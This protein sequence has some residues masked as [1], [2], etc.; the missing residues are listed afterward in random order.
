MRSENLVLR[1]E[2]EQFQSLL[3]RLAF[4]NIQILN[5]ELILLCPSDSQA[6]LAF[7]GSIAVFP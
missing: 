1:A 5:D 3:V 7:T 6:R 2:L 4:K